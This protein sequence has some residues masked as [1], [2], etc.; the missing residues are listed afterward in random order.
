MDININAAIKRFVAAAQA[1]VDT[2][3]HGGRKVL[4]VYGG[5][6]YARVELSFENGGSSRSAYCYVEYSTGNILRAVGMR[7]PTRH[8]VG[9]VYSGNPT[10][11]LGP[12]G[13]NL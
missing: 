8:V 10:E 12:H 2:V 5:V 3:D 1:V 11:G 4:T 9:N 6:R 7:G 13:A